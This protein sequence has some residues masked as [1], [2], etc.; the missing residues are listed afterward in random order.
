M[1]TSTLFRKWQKNY[2]KLL[3]FPPLCVIIKIQRGGTAMKDAY[4]E[5]K[6]IKY[7]L[8]LKELKKQEELKKGKEVA[9]NER[10][11][12]LLGR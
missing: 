2:K 8:I 5:Y 3:T 9:E 4:Y 6:R 12:I 11:K 1:T 7:E 10:N